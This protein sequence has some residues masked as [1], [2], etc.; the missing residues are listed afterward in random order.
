MNVYRVTVS[1]DGD[2]LRTYLVH[3]V[4]A[5]DAERAAIEQVSEVLSAD[6]AEIADIL[7][8]DGEIEA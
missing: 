4:T 3:A 2:E 5:A 8:F 6:A 1:A 7:D